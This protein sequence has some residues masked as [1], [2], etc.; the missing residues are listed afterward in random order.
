M[1][2]FLTT[3]HLVA[4]TKSPGVAY[5]DEINKLYKPVKKDMWDYTKSISHG[6][7][8]KVVDKR[9]SELIETSNTAL[10]NAKKLDGFNGNEKLKDSIVAYFTI[11]NLVLKEDYAKLVDLEAI[12]EDSYDAMEAYMS[13][14]DKANDKWGEAAKAV[15]KEYKE[16]AKEN[17]ITLIDVDDELEK[18]MDIAN[19]VYEHYN[20]VYLIFFKSYKQEVYALDAIVKKDI[21]ALEQNRMAL[22]A[23]AEE[24]LEKL[25]STNPYS[26]DKAMVYATQELLKFYIDEVEKVFVKTSDYLLKYENFEKIK[27][28][29]EKIKEKNRTKDDVDEYNNA[30]N[31]LNE[32]AKA[33][34]DTNKAS[35]DERSKL[36]DNWNKTASKYT[37]KYVP[38]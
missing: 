11:V 28:S 3:S 29:F 13:A 8:A 31:E 2:V 17:N 10:F 27:T 4:Q 18:K 26:N 1:V 30:A 15:D 16:F 7:S 23:T 25:K 38:N 24:G 35:Y 19:D 5:L 36:I 14:K 12:A 20:E 37:D 33:Y 6:R 22:K 32:A 9:R 21:N 34:N